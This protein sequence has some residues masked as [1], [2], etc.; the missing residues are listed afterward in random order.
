[1]DFSYEYTAE[2]QRFRAQVSGWLNANVPDDMDALIDSP[3]GASTLAG[4]SIELGR[5]GWLAPSEPTDSGGAGLSPDQTVVILEE[6][7]R[8]GLLWLVEGETQA[9]RCAIG[10]W[11]SANSKTGLVRPLATGQKTVWQHRIGLSPQ[12]DGDIGLDPDSV[13]ITATPDAD[14]YI[15]NGTGIFTT[16]HGTRPDI[17]WA[18]ALVQPESNSQ[19]DLPEPVCLL[20][21]ANSDGIAYPS[22]RMLIPTAPA[23][24]NFH[25]VWVLRTDA[26]GPEGE[27]HRVLSTRVTLDTRADLPS[28]VESETDALIEYA[29]E[30]ELGADPIRA[31]L[32]VEAYIASRVSRLLRMQAALLEQNTAEIGTAAPLASLSQRVAASELSDTATQVVGPAAM[33]AAADPRAADA[34]RF[35]RISR[36]ELSERESGS[37]G[38]PNREAIASALELGDQPD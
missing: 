24:V 11:D 13:G 21:D 36:R 38:D 31:K 8:R 15:L 17:L 10:N 7:N 27:G 14:G 32:L 30:N 16:G 19:N 2:Q 26:L 18:A 29:R 25:D 4:L 3:Y 37:T 1:M 20:I 12:P 6:L 33:L 23:P 28:W 22:A 34:G 35:D 9:L 5:K